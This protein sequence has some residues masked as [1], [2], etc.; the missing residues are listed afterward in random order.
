VGEL[1]RRALLALALQGAVLCSRMLRCPK[2]KLPKRTI[3][4]L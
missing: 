2:G 4:I 3:I 1:L